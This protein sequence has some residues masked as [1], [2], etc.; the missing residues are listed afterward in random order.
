M[1]ASIVDVK[2]YNWKEEVLE[3]E[4]LVLIKFWSPQCPHCR[5]IAPIYTELSKEYAGKLKFAR[6][7]IIESHQNQELAI[8]LGVMGTPT[9]KFFC[10]GRPVQDIV[11]ALPKDDLE[12]AIDFAINNHERCIEKSTTTQYVR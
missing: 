8:R 5:M 9:F 12:Q 11:G 6:L 1:S 4:N 2:A 3:S 10:G 7:N